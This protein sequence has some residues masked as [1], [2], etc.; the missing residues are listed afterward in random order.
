MLPT[1][2]PFAFV[3]GARLGKVERRSS[4]RILLATAV[5][6]ELRMTSTVSWRPGTGVPAFLGGLRSFVLQHAAPS[7]AE[8]VCARLDTVTLSI[9]SLVAPSAREC[10]RVASHLLNASVGAAFTPYAIWFPKVGVV[11]DF[12]QRRVSSTKLH[13]YFALLVGSDVGMSIKPAKGRRLSRFATLRAMR[14]AHNGLA[15]AVANS[16]NSF[17]R[18]ANLGWRPKSAHGRRS[19]ELARLIM[20]A[21]DFALLESTDARPLNATE[22]APIFRVARDESG[23]VVNDYG[24]YDGLRQ[25]VFASWASK[26]AALPRPAG[27]P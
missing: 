11:Q 24:I 5:G 4:R 22:M 2:D 15:P 6:T 1:R 26:L 17:E 14:S 16:M 25:V 20:N 21:H 23:I 19:I 10:A 8:K 3:E 13:P 12:R 18:F 9:L 27:R 7:D